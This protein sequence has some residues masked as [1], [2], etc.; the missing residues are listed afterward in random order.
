[1]RVTNI[2]RTPVQLVGLEHRY[3]CLAKGVTELPPGGIVLAIADD[4][5][6]PAGETANIGFLKIDEQMVSHRKEIDSL[7]RTAVFH[8]RVKYFAFIEPSEESAADYCYVYV[9]SHEVLARS[10]EYNPNRRGQN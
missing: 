7:D 8:G 2:G 6:I 4:R 5:T 1:L 3:S 9:P 10:N